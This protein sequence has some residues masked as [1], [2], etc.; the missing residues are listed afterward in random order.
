MDQSSGSHEEVSC[1][2]H[3]VAMTSPGPLHKYQITLVPESRNRG[4]TAAVVFIIPIPLSS[5]RQHFSVE[6][7]WGSLV[8]LTAPHLYPHH[9]GRFCRTEDSMNLRSVS[10]PRKSKKR[11]IGVYLR[12]KGR[13][14]FHDPWCLASARPFALLF[15]TLRPPSSR[16]RSRWFV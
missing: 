16:R 8:L 11:G 14:P 12:M 5:F 4:G 2:D 3:S 10:V 13:V 7:V 6:L 1:L 15:V 9:V